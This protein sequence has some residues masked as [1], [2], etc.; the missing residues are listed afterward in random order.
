MSWERA[1]GAHNSRFPLSIHG[2]ATP[3]EQALSSRPVPQT[4]TECGKWGN[5]G[6]SAKSEIGNKTEVF[7]NIP[8]FLICDLSLRDCSK[9]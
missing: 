1:L 7:I 9:S 4:G 2:A 5:C 8:D 3:G 6:E